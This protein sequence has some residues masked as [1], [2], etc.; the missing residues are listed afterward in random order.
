M[1]AGEQFPGAVD[2]ET[3]VDHVQRIGARVQILREE[4]G[5]ALE[6]PRAMRN[7]SKRIRS[8]PGVADAGRGMSG[9]ST[10]TQPCSPA[11]RWEQRLRTQSGS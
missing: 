11:S 1:I 7:C 10:T 6:D 5:D 3:L 4:F 2:I 9:I 8:E